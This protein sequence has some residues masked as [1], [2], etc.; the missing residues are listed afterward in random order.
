[1]KKIVYISLLLITAR[2]L[3]AQELFPTTEPASTVPTGVLGMRYTSQSYRDIGGRVKHSS[4]FRLMY[5][6]NKNFSVIFSG[7]VSNHHY[8][9]LPTDIG[10]YYLN[11]HKINYPA[12]PTLFDGFNLYA[13]YR[14]LSIDEP[15]KHLRFAIYGE[16]SNASVAHDE[17]EPNLMGDNAGYGGG[18]IVTRLHKRFALSVTTGFIVPFTYKDKKNPVTFRSGNCWEYDVSLGYRLYPKQY[19]DYGN[20]NINIYT[21][22]IN[23]AYNSAYIT[24]NGEQYSYNAFQNWSP[25]IY[26]SLNEGKYSEMRS[27]IQFII[28]SISRI[29][30]TMAVPVYNGSYTKRYPVLMINLQHYFFDKKNI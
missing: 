1:L 4:A 27:S 24:K 25:Y 20:L 3:S 26:N 2:S 17:A 18:L 11:H 6:V 16:A 12:S 15:Q 7:C 8:R 14:F 29:D 21:E 9:N 5:G 23:K 13:K 30:L 22:F 19:S 28:N 10:Y